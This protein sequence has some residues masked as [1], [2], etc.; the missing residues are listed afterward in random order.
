MDMDDISFIT[1]YKRISDKFPEMDGFLYQLCVVNEFHHIIDKDP[2]ICCKS[3]S[4]LITRSA[5][6]VVC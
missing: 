3:F 1:R 2:N 5:S 4:F 6:R